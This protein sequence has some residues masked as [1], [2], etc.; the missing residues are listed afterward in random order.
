MLKFT[1]MDNGLGYNSTCELFRIYHPSEGYTEDGTW[2]I[3]D[4]SDYT[5]DT[6]EKCGTKRE[7]VGQANAWAT[8]AAA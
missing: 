5:G 8:E 2:I 6:I 1:R 7:C 4:L 3:E